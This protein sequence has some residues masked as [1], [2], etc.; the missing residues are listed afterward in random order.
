MYNVNIAKLSSKK[1]KKGKSHSQLAVGAVSVR[2]PH[3]SLSMACEGR[4]P[5]PLPW[6]PK[7]S[8]APKRVGYPFA[9]W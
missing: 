4:C 1:V 8:P 5:S 2:I 9:A 3:V 6:P 7:P